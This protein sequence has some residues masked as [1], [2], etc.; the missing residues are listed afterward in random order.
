MTLPVILFWEKIPKKRK[1]FQL[2]GIQDD[3]F[4]DLMVGLAVA[5]GFLVVRNILPFSFLGWVIPDTTPLATGP[6]V[7]TV[8]G[9]AP[10]VEELFFRVMFFAVLYGVLGLPFW[11]ASPINNIGFSSYHVIA[12]A[13]ELALDPI[14]SVSGAFI[15]AGLAGMVMDGVNYWR[16]SATTSWGTHFGLNFSS[17]LS[18]ALTFG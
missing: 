14:I 18:G 2:Y 5:G 8:L 9:I 17:W 1:N 3:W 13:N 11:I 7:A 4:L 16:G 10:I 15:T 12:Y 6:Q